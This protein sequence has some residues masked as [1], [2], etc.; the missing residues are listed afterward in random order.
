MTFRL[1]RC[2]FL[3]YEPFPKYI[4]LLCLNGGDAKRPDKEILVDVRQCRCTIVALRRCIIHKY[5]PLHSD[6]KRKMEISSMIIGHYCSFMDDL[7]LDCSFILLHRCA[8]VL[9]HL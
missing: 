2:F 9:R 3:F 4:M 6:E 1:W 5:P 7:I 8:Q